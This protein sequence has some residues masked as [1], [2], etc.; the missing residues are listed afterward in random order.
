MKRQSDDDEN[1][2]DQ[3]REELEYANS[4]FSVAQFNDAGSHGESCKC[5]KLASLRKVLTLSLCQKMIISR[6][7]LRNE[8]L[9]CKLI[10]ETFGFAR[11]F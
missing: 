8:I 3:T 6:L 11:L 1:Q 2:T 9:I 4:A 5:C 7:Q 10:H